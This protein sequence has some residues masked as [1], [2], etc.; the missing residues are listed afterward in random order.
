LANE[1]DESTDLVDKRAVGCRRIKS[2]S[3]L[4][5]LHYSTALKRI[6]QTTS[7]LGR[8]RRTKGRGGKGLASRHQQ[9]SKLVVDIVVNEDPVAA[10]AR[11]ARETELAGDQ[12]LD[13]RWEVGVGED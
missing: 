11:L 7:A 2:R 10:D 13:G 6:D 3:E 8:S 5:L 12:T 4:E 1:G 9:L